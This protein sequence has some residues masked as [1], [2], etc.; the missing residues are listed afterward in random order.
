VNHRGGGL[1]PPCP[2]PT[3]CFA[4]S[5]LPVSFFTRLNP[6]TGIN[7]NGKMELRMDADKRSSRVSWQNFPVHPMRCTMPLH[8]SET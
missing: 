2:P 6:E 3:A 8:K 7:L 1:H 5:F 4:P